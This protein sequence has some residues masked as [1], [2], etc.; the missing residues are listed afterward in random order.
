[1]VGK[2]LHGMKTTLDVSIIIANYNTKDLTCDCLQ[3]VFER[4]DCIAFEVI[5]SDNG[6]SDGSQEMI[7][8]E[9]PQ[10]VLIENGANIGFGAANNCALGVAA[11]FD[12]FKKDDMPLVYAD[13]SESVMD[14][15]L[16][17]S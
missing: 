16:Q 8:A 1:M 14:L 7:R 9:F 11:L 5:V 17:D 3:S 15:I 4:T 6:S 10:V 2:R 13:L 12:S